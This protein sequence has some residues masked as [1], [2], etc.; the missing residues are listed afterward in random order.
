MRNV[1]PSILMAL[2][3]VNAS[4]TFLCPELNI[5]DERSDGH[6]HSLGRRGMIQ[7]LVVLEA[8]GLQFIDIQDDFVQPR[9][10]HASGLEVID[11][12]QSFNLVW[13][14]GVILSA[15]PVVLPG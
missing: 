8:D 6:L 13:D 15:A 2:P 4:P 10:R 3:L 9:Q 11:R 14:G 5:F 12:G 7:T 1:P